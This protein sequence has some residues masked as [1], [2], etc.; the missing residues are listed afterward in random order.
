MRYFGGMSAEEIGEV[1]GI[2]PVTVARD[3]R[4]AKAWLKLHLAGGR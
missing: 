1:L 4:A 2:A 3:V